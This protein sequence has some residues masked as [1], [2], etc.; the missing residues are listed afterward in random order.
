MKVKQLI[1][2]LKKM[3]QNLEVYTSAH[4]NSSWETAG[5]TSSV[6]HHAKEDL[7]EEWDLNNMLSKEDLEWF[8]DNP[9]EWVVINS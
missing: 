6:D 5:Y 9:E 2:I 3:P 1:A 8:E 7:R 4:D